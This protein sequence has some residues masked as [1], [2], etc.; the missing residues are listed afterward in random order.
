M[1]VSTWM[2]HCLIPVDYFLRE[3]SR[4]YPDGSFELQFNTRP[5]WVWYPKIVMRPFCVAYQ[6]CECDRSSGCS[7]WY[8]CLLEELSEKGFSALLIPTSNHLG[9]NDGNSWWMGWLVCVTYKGNNLVSI[10][11]TVALPC[12]WKVWRQKERIMETRIFHHAKPKKKSSENSLKGT[13][14]LQD[15]TIITL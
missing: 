5:T 11:H 13:K 1:Q 14:I 10:C 4:W 3:P 9:T 6:K 7:F 15:I 8:D 2:S 12:T